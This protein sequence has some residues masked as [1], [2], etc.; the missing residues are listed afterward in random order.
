MLSSENGAVDGYE[1]DLED[2]KVRVFTRNGIFQARLYK[3][4]R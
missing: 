3:G 2:G 1:E 4:D